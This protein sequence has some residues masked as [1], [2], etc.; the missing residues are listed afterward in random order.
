MKGRIDTRS[1]APRGS[2]TLELDA[3]ALDGIAILVE[4][5]APQAASEFRRR[6]G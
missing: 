3:R 2:V 4:K 5:I 1:Q 6:A